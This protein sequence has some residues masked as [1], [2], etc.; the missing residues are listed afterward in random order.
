MNGDINAVTL[1]GADPMEGVEASYG[2]RS[3]VRRQAH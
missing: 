1:L 3:T 2:E